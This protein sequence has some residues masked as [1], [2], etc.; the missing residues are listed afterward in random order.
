VIA[1]RDTPCTLPQLVKALIVLAAQGKVEK[2]QLGMASDAAAPNSGTATVPLA[3]CNATVSAAMPPAFQ[4]AI[5]LALPD[6]V[7]VRF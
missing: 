3:T 4:H 1:C 5:P 7:L 2:M 6:A